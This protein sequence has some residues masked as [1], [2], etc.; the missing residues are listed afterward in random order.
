VDD[1]SAEIPKQV[2][3]LGGVSLAM[4]LLQSLCTA[5][6]AISGI[7]VAIGLG[8]LAAVSGVYAPARGW[9]QDAIR[10][11]MLIFATAGA[12]VNLAV[13]GWI[14]RLRAQGSAQWRRKELTKR[15]RRSERLQV[16]L[17]I[18][19]LLLVGLETWT[20]PMVHRTGPAPTVREVRP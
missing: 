18:L 16:V 2:R 15:Q 20:H 10:I 1:S 11:P 19:T 6:F 4:A 13:L 8:A 7:R 3:A 5:V 14:W 9:H 17:A 12:V